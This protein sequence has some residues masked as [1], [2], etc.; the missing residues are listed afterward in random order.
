[1]I[2]W[3]EYEG[4]N[5]DVITDEDLHRDGVARF[6]PYRVV[7]SGSHPEY[8][9]S[10]MLDALNAYLHAGGRHMYLGGNG[11]YWVTSS[12]PERTHVIEVRRWGGTGAW[13]AEPG[14]YHHSTTGELG[15]LWRNRGRSPQAIVGVG[16]TAQGFDVARPYDRQPGSYAEEVSWI[17]D[18]VEN[19]HGIGDLP[20]HILG[21]GAAGHEIDRF[22]RRLGTPAHTHLLA[23]ATGFSDGYQGVVED[24]LMN[25]SMQ[26][27]RV[28]PRVRAD[29]VYVTYSNGGAVF[30]VGSIAWIGALSANN[31][32][33]DVARITGNVLRRLAG[34]SPTRVQ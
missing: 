32:E 5:V 23:T 17:F 10:Q 30:S 19:H 6:A 11:Y 25:D 13:R 14:E 34:L 2:D 8:W 22:D 29:M 12:C 21:H 3:L 20:N 33:N 1:L 26:G 31:Y 15:G 16:F 7:I 9:S 18:G 27:G 24:V 4:I 28:N